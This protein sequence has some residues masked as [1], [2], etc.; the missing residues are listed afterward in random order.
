MRTLDAQRAALCRAWLAM[1]NSISESAERFW[2]LHGL[3]ASAEALGVGRYFYFPC[4]AGPRTE[5]SR[6]LAIVH[7]VSV[8]LGEVITVLDRDQLDDAQER[9]LR[10]W[11]AA[12]APFLH[13][14]EAPPPPPP[15]G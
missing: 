4:C 11:P 15:R 14:V 6:G 2:Q 9:V 7:H 3:P 1:T 13:Q 8:L 10:L 5:Q 12:T